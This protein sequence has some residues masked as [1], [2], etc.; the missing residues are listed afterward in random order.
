MSD[1]NL[2]R[3]SRSNTKDRL[4]MPPPPLVIELSSRDGNKLLVIRSTM[5]VY[6]ASCHIFYVKLVDSKPSPRQQAM[7]ECFLLPGKGHFVPG[8]LCAIPNTYFIISI[9]KDR[10]TSLEKLGSAFFPCP[11]I[12]G[13]SDGNSSKDQG[14][15]QQAVALTSLSSQSDTI[16]RKKLVQEDGSVNV[17]TYSHWI[18]FTNI[19]QPSQSFDSRDIYQILNQYSERVSCNIDIESKGMPFKRQASPTPCMIRDLRI[20]APLTIVN[21]LGTGVTIAVTPELESAGYTGE[22]EKLFEF[23]QDLQDVVLQNYLRSGEAKE[24]F[25]FHARDP[26]NLSLKYAN[27]G[28]SSNNKWCK[29]IRIPSCQDDAQEYPSVYLAD[30]L[31]KNESILTIQ[32]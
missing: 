23:D 29:L 17:M 16:R 30:I 18:D 3:R 21:L 26:V 8:E 5:R 22:L 28:S 12:P 14:A 11:P 4:S 20:Q 32:V 24:Y 9:R 31:F 1:K 27:D 19:S 15:S 10:E 7:W 25:C 2:K 13:F 6:N